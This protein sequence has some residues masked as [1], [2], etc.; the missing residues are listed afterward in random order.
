MDVF[1]V[2]VMKKNDWDFWLSGTKN[3]KVFFSKPLL[4]YYHIITI[5][6]VSNH[7]TIQTL[8]VLLTLF[9]FSPILV[10]NIQLMSS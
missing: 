5:Y 6:S 2:Y 7:W 8:M 4:P 10:R 3:C 9:H 1:T